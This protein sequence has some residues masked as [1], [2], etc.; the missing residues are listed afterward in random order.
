MVFNWNKAK[1][2]EIEQERKK[3]RKTMSRSRT[4]MHIEM[5]GWTDNKVLWK[6]NIAGGKKAEKKQSL[7]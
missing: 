1:V 5:K 2:F 6:R 4:Q 3:A 7:R